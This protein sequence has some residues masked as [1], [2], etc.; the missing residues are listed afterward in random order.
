LVVAIYVALGALSWWGALAWHSW[1]MF[2]FGALWWA[3]G[4]LLGWRFYV[5]LD[6]ESSDGDP[7]A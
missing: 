7:Y 3:V 6:D 2:A 4:I 5:A 1:A